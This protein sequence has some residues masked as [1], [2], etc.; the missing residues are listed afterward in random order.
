MPESVRTESQAIHS[1]PCHR[2]LAPAEVLRRQRRSGKSGAD[3]EAKTAPAVGAGKTASPSPPSSAP[4]GHPL[5]QI[6]PPQHRQ[7]ETRGKQLLRPPSKREKRQ[8]HPAMTE[9]LK[10]KSIGLPE[11]ADAPPPDVFQVHDAGLYRDLRDSATWTRFLDKERERRRRQA[12][13]QHRAVKAEEQQ[14]REELQQTVA[15][16]ANRL[17]AER[18]RKRAEER[19]ADDLAAFFRR[20]DAYFDAQQHFMEVGRLLTN[21]ERRHKNRVREELYRSWEAVHGGGAASSTGPSPADATSPTDNTKT[22]ATAVSGGLGT[23]LS[24]TQPSYARVNGAD[25]A[26]DSGAGFLAASTMHRRR[27]QGQMRAMGSRNPKDRR[28]VREDDLRH[29][30]RQTEEAYVVLSLAYRSEARA[31]QTAALRTSSTAVAVV[32]RPEI[33]DEGSAA[34]LPAAAVLG[35][36]RDSIFICPKPPYLHD[37]QHVGEAAASLPQTYV[38]PNFESAMLADEGKAPL[39]GPVGRWTAGTF[40]YGPGYQR[41]RRPHHLTSE[42]DDRNVMPLPLLPYPVSRD[43]TAELQVQY[44]PW[45]TRPLPEAGAASRRVDDDDLSVGFVPPRLPPP[46]RDAYLPVQKWGAVELQDTQYG[47]YSTEDGGVRPSCERLRAAASLRS[48]TAV[49][50]SGGGDQSR[51]LKPAP[52]HF[53]KRMDMWMQM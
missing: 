11:E 34:A 26:C 8:S 20:S 10:D 2:I 23:P 51:F 16:E 13:V 41:R 4:S 35:S 49:P 7:Q 19:A 32:G 48:N 33:P 46:P 27:E 14:R 37:P 18:T 52:L 9:T 25:I 40:S 42:A 3:D 15:M 22:G 39:G 5:R 38:P 12:L 50:L 43:V 30:A 29:E 53:G 45:C 6:V 17:A 36:P 21:G 24:C 1:P 28:L 31:A 47:R 44:Y